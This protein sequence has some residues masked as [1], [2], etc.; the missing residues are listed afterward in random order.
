MNSPR[1]RTI[2]PDSLRIRL[3]AHDGATSDA[4]AVYKKIMNLT[5]SV[6]RT[7]HSDDI[8]DTV[9]AVR[10]YAKVWIEYPEVSSV[11][12]RMADSLVV[13]GNQ[14]ESAGDDGGAKEARW[15]ALFACS[16]DIQSGRVIQP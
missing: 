16:R 9:G 15:C 10:G 8:F 12:Q 4:V 13:L 3:F 1:P 7:V 14:L 2:P 11:R 6:L 5:F